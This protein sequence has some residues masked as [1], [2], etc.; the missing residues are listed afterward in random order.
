MIFNKTDR[1]ALKFIG[2]SFGHA[3]E[4]SLQ[5][6]S[7]I[8][9]AELLVMSNSPIHTDIEIKAYDQTHTLS[10]KDKNYRKHSSRYIRTMN[11]TP[12]VPYS[13]PTTFNIDFCSNSDKD[14]TEENPIWGLA[15]IYGDPTLP[16]RHVSLVVS[17]QIH[18]YTFSHLLT[19]SLGPTHGSLYLLGEMRHPLSATPMMAFGPATEPTSFTY[20]LMNANNLSRTI[21]NEEIDIS[22]TLLPA[23]TSAI[24]HLPP[25]QTNEINFL[26]I[27]LYVNA[28]EPKM[29]IIHTA[30]KE[31]VRIGDIVTYT[32]TIINEG[33]TTAECMQFR[34]GFPDGTLFISDSLTV[35]NIPV[36]VD[37]SDRLLLGNMSIGDTKTIVYKIKITH[38]PNPAF[39]LHQPVLDYNFTPL[40]HTLAVGNQPSSIS[41]VFVQS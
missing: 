39:I 21:L 34:T 36:V 9:H 28:A 7:Y 1:L 35:D 11:V 16:V 33:T 17:E 32:T 31:H 24:L 38:K 15:I 37:P 29:T 12:F 23:Q 20:P 8:L 22:S 10:S 19:P 41:K 5:P 2:H 4:F 27:G 30:N 14:T 6:T 3:C 13:G 25:E 26:A 40:Q 18:T